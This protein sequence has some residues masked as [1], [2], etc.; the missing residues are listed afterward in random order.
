M[1]SSVIGHGL[2]RGPTLPNGRVPLRPELPDGLPPLP[3]IQSE[4]LRLQVFTHRSFY[5]RPTHVFEDMPDDPSPDNESLEHLGDTVLSLV[6]T[7][8]MR[9]VYPCLRVRR[10]AV[11]GNPTLAWISVQ[12]RLP[13]RLRMHPAQAITLRASANIQ[14]QSERARASPSSEVFTS[15]KVS[16]WSRTGFTSSSVP[17]SPWRTASS[18]CSTACPPSRRTPPPRPRPTPSPPPILAVP[19]TTAGVT[20]TGD[21]RGRGRHVPFPPPDMVDAAATAHARR[22]SGDLSL[23]NQHLQQQCKNVEWVYVDSA[24]EGTKTTPIWVVRAMVEGQCLGSGR[25]STKKAA[26]N[27]AAKEGLVRLGVPVPQLEGQFPL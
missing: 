25:G 15:T 21:R 13:E 4:A 19:P 26:R 24:G 12:Y 10:R 22:A 20:G 1:A 5:A 18:A 17:S 7:G 2:P 14:E 11:Y 3:E 27:E 16:R 6:V 9:E 23:F 8:L